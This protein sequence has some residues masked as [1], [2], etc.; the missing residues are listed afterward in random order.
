MI[1]KAL[2][3]YKSS[4]RTEYFEFLNQPF[5][6]GMVGFVA[7][8]QYENQEPFLY[9]WHGTQMLKWVK[10]SQG[11]YSIEFYDH[12]RY[13]KII[14]PVLSIHKEFTFPHPRNINDLLNDL[15]RCEIDTQWSDY[16]IKHNDAKHILSNSE[17]KTYIEDLLNQIGK[18]GGN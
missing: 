13:Y 18:S 14:N 9:D 7:G 5:R 10:Y 2:P 1:F 11:K 3:F 15:D 8:E 4:R 17:Y 6:I 12:E 16:I